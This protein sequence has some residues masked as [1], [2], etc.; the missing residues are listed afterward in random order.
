MNELVEKKS[1]EV[2]AAEI[3]ALTASMLS[4]I[5]EIGRRMCQAKEMLPHGEFGA[6]VKDETGYSQSTANN[7]MRLFQ[8]YGAA[9]ESLFGAEIKS[10][11]FGNL[12]YSKALA[13]LAIPAEERE[14]F[15]RENHVEEMSTRELKQ[16]I[17][18]RDELRRQLNEERAAAE[19]ASLRISDLEEKL[20]ALKNAPVEVAVQAADPEEVQRA[21][22]E[23]LQKARAAHREELEAVA[24]EAKKAN[25]ERDKLK[26]QLKQVLQKAEAAPESANDG[27]AQR[28]VERLKKELAM[29]DPVVAE[30]KGLFEQASGLV[31][32]L[33]GLVDCAPKDK[34]G[35]LRNALAALGK[36]M[37]V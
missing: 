30:F 1:P 35:N 36:Q 10:Q 26:K 18:E 27:A 32:K 34:Q 23:A 37:V 12:P 4:T 24:E 17:K 29:A 28:E 20:E 14:E 2:L 21:V 9:Q 15:A 16:A 33:L 11:T 25:E 22:D 13:L 5:I 31:A 19:G 7:F 6:W 3:R 8:E